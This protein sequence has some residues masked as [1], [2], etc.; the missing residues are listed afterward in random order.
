MRKRRAKARLGDDASWAQKKM[1]DAVGDQTPQEVR[2][3]VTRW[4]RILLAVALVLAV[5]GAFLYRWSWVAGVAAHALALGAGFFWF[6][7]RRQR[8]NFVQTAEW[9][10]RL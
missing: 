3:M 2:A 10:R 1:I 4:T 6:R 9:M 8:E 7:F 5:G